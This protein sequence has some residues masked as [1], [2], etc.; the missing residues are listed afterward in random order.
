MEKRLSVFH[1]FRLADLTREEVGTFIDNWCREAEHSVRKDPSEAEA[2]GRKAAEDLKQ[3][4]G[5]N[6]AVERI[7]VNPLLVTVL[8]VVHRFLGKAIPE[9]RVKLYEKC[10]DALLYEWDR[11]KFPEGAAI[12]KLDAPQQRKLLMGI[13][14]LLHDAHQAE[15]EESQVVRHFEK[16]LPTLGRPAG[17]ARKIVIEIRD[18]SGLLVERRPGYFAFSH[19]TFQEYLTAL[20]YVYGKRWKKLVD[21]FEDAWWQEVIPL[22]AGVEGSDPGRIARDL[23]AKKKPEAVILAAQCLETAID[24]PLA[25]RRR[26]E[27][28]LD[29]FL[30]PRNFADVWRLARL[31]VTVAP[32]LVKALPQT[33]GPERRLTLLALR[34]IEY[35]PA[36]PAI[37]ASTSEE[38]FGQVA[39]TVLAA[40][41][42][43]SDTARRALKAALPHQSVDFLT[44][45]RRDR[46]L[47]R[48]VADLLDS[49]IRAAHQAGR[50]AKRARSTA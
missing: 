30:P 10:T 33:G 7:A 37:A 11:A 48:E 18:R 3:R 14:R 43:T 19:L 16:I 31:G 22:A 45:L 47:P 28:E 29:R 25:V 41:A 36:I 21:K 44:A 13:A 15:I 8:C 20:D 5:R 2:E 39:T 42:R 6:P 12:G 32:L 40:K 26:I 24:M 46:A 49:A 4:L 34:D 38:V 35:D 23:L 9:H 17:D 27:K 1:P 50:P